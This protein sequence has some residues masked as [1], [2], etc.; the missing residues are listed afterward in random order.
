MNDKDQK[1]QR[2]QLLKRLREEHQDSVQCTLD[3]IKKYKEIRKPIRT[4]MKEGAK[5]IPE[6]AEATGLP[7]DKILWHVTAL[8]KHGLVVEAEMIGDYYQYQLAQ[9]PKK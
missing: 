4:A 5:T 9:E 8:K 3:M 7:A 2:A 1:K 6:L